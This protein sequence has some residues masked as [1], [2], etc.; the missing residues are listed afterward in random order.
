[1]ES[2]FTVDGVTIEVKKTPEKPKKKGSGCGLLSL[3]FVVL[4][5]VLAIYI[6][7]GPSSSSPSTVPLT[8]K[9]TSTPVP[10]WAA[11]EASF[12]VGDEVAIV[13]RG[14]VH[15]RRTPGYRNKPAGDDVCRGARSG[16]RF[17]IV[18]GPQYVDDIWWWQVSNERCPE[19]WIAQTRWNGE[20]ILSRP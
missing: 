16:E 20:T 19:G 4:F 2:R 5:A 13:L 17:R 3:L 11:K 12:G 9:A 1:M 15:V 14:Q 10:I 8:G 18:G 6:L 7:C